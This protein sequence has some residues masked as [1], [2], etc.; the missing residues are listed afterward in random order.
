MIKKKDG[1]SFLKKTLSPSFGFGHAIIFI[2]WDVVG[3]GWVVELSIDLCDF[4]GLFF[5]PADVGGVLFPVVSFG[6]FR[7]PFHFV[8][9]VLFE[10]IVDEVLANPAGAFF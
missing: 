2:D 10:F 5:G 3:V 8:E 4:F 9:R 7:V 6:H 1:A